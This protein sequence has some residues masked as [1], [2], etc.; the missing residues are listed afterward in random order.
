M[1]GHKFGE[2]AFTLFLWEKSFT[3][4]DDG[5]YDIKNKILN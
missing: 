1:V 4:E 3:L 2:F 5:Y